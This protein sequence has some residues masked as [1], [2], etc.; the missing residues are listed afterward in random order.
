MS[1]RRKGREAT[2]LLDYKLR[3]PEALRRQIAEMAEKNRV[4]ANRE[5]INRLWRSFEQGDLFTLADV[6]EEFR[7]IGKRYDDAIRAMEMQG[8][9]IRAVEALTT[10]V[11]QL[12]EL[13]EPIQ[14]ALK[15]TKTVIWMIEREAAQLPRRMRTTGAD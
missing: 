12:P 2:Q 14:A 11:E 10:A 5:M 1:P 7:N 4:S 8:D 15:K 13:N 3:I 6:A 9:L